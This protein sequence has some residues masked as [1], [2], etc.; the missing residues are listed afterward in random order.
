MH[1][2]LQGSLKQ[3]Q[4]V[5]Q[6]LR[7]KKECDRGRRLSE[8][9]RGCSIKVQSRNSGSTQS[10]LS[11][12][13][14][15]QQQQVQAAEQRWAPWRGGLGGSLYGAISSGEFSSAEPSRPSCPHASDVST[16]LNRDGRA[17]AQ[18]LPWTNCSSPPVPK[19]RSSRSERY[20]HDCGHEPVGTSASQPSHS[21]LP[22]G[23]HD[24]GTRSN[25]ANSLDGCF[26]FCFPCRYGQQ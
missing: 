14:Q 12:Q 21:T 26:P 22:Y 24:A 3:T 4:V 1:R 5:T 23:A 15:Q 2:A 13:Q 10:G 19:R 16:Q 25:V 7:K 6:N 9:N 17:A 18:I 8:G 11:Q 20:G